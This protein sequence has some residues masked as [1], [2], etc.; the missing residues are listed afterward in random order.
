M[1]RRLVRSPAAPKIV[2]VAGGAW[3]LEARIVTVGAVVGAM[4]FASLILLP[5][6]VREP[7]QWIGTGSLRVGTIHVTSSSQAMCKGAREIGRCPELRDLGRNLAAFDQPGFSLD[8][9]ER[10][11]CVLAP[12]ADVEL[13]PADA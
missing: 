13:V 5:C 12:E 3:R 2:M 11:L 10:S 8:H 1:T 6:E 7:L 4:V 9:L